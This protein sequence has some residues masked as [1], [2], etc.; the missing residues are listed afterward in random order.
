MSCTLLGCPSIFPS[1]I[2]YSNSIHNILSTDPS[3]CL[4]DFASHYDN[5]VY[6]GGLSHPWLP[7]MASPT[8]SSGLQGA[9]TTEV[10]RGAG[11]PLTIISLLLGKRCSSLVPVEQRP[12]VVSWCYIA[13]PL[14]HAHFPELLNSFSPITA[15]LA[16]L[17]HLNVLHCVFQEASRSHLVGALPGCSSLSWINTPL[18]NLP[19]HYPST[20]THNIQARA[21]LSAPGPFTCSLGV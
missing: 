10:L 15:I 17:S 19:F 16:H 11:A 3:V 6:L 7:E 21:P 14:Q 1:E 13:H 9:A 8:I 18:F 12:L 4:Y 2:L 5:C 20:S